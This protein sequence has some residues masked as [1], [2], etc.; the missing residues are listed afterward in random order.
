MGKIRSNLLFSYWL[1][2]KGLKKFSEE[3][4][5]HRK[6]TKNGD[7]KKKIKKSI[8]I[9]DEIKSGN[10]LAS[11]LIE[12]NIKNFPQVESIELPQKRPAKSI[13]KKTCLSNVEKIIDNKLLGNEILQNVTDITLD[14]VYFYLVQSRKITK[15]NPK[16]YYYKSILWQSNKRRFIWSI[17]RIYK[18]FSW[19]TNFKASL[20]NKIIKIFSWRV[21]W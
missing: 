6:I 18:L 17:W 9:A 5:E 20:Y 4:S 13:N 11:D 8:K 7:W 2:E 16:F 21:Y 12:I 14:I 15:E 3:N 1:T 10:L 19:F